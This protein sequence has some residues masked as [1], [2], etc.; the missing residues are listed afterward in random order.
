VL[1]GTDGDIAALREWWHDHASSVGDD[2]RG[3]WFGLAV[4]QGDDGSLRHTMYVAGT[5]S[6]GPDDGG[7]WACEYVWE[8]K[9]RYVQLPFLAAIG[10]SD[11]SRALDHA[12][13]VVLNAKPW[14]TGP[15][16]L[17]GVGVGFD[18]GDVEIVWARR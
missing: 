2:V 7:D 14:E 13:M 11:W 6:F 12:V 18:D 10:T 8:P 4:L 3:L 15:S 17:N 5:P 1:P 9:D 16:T